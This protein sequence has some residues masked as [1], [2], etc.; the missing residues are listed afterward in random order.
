MTI[1]ETH[2]FSRLLQVTKYIFIV[3]TGA[4]ALSGLLF[5][6]GRVI[7][8]EQWVV[9]AFFNT[10]AHL[11]WIPSLL[12]LPMMLLIRQWRMALLLLP[13]V[14]M[15]LL[16]YGKQF[17]VGNNEAPQNAIVITVLTH[18]IF[19]DNTDT[20]AIINLIRSADADIVAMQEV[21]Y[22]MAEAFERQLSTE[23]PYQAL[24]PQ[25]VSVQGMVVLSRFPIVDDTYWQYDW[26]RT[27]LAHERLLIEVSAE[28]S[29]VVYNS[30][31]THPGMND[32]AF[33]P[34]WRSRELAAIYE[35][36]QAETLPII[37]LGD[38][39]MP[40][41]SDDYQQITQSFEDVYQR[42]GWGMGWTFPVTLRLIPLLRI[43]YIFISH[44]FEAMESVLLDSSG[45]SDH[46]PLTATIALPNQ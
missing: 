45:G 21:N 33:N 25:D 38:F 1:S 35:R 20:E 19:G 10:F 18:N 22:T 15:F 28:Q 3:I 40:H 8:G 23:Y 29:I 37:W 17:I 31:P 12:L 43:D 41:L 9:I 32:S 5:L 30:H 26:L 39:N 7:I 11:L 24:H 44:E 46:L 2:F 27:P 42:V 14:L 36:T 4:Y 6:L 13:S 16:I 34:S